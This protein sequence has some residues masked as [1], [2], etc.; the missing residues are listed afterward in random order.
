MCGI[1]GVVFGNRSMRNKRG[2]KLIEQLF[3]LSESQGKEAAG[4]RNRAKPCAST[5]QRTKR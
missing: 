2:A 1:F 5:P 4:H 3:L